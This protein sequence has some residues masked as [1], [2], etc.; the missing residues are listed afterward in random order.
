MT[1][2]ISGALRINIIAAFALLLW[3]DDAKGTNK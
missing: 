2:F 1:R 3:L